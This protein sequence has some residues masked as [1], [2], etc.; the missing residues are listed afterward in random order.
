MVRS[1]ID[2]TL[3]REVDRFVRRL[4]ETGGPAIQAAALV[5][6]IEGRAVRALSGSAGRDRPGGW[7]DLTE[8]RRSPGSTL[9]PFVYALAFEDGTAAPQTLIED[10]PARFATYQPENFDRSF[11]GEVTVAQA[12][13]HSLNVPAV[14]VLDRVGAGRFASSLRFAGAD[15]EIPGRL[16]GAAGLALALGGLG[17]SASDLALLYAALG[18]GGLGRPLSLTEAEAQTS[19]S[20]P[21]ARLVSA[22]AAGEVLDILYASPSP[23]GRM[24]AGLAQGAPTVAYKTGT[25]YGF[26]DAWAAGVAGDYV[27]VVW[28]GRPDGAPRPGETGRLA[29]LPTLFDIVDAVARLDPAGVVPSNQGDSRLAP[30]PLPL[31]VFAR[32]GLP[33]DILFPPDGAELWAETAGRDFVLSGRGSGPLRWYV[34]GAPAPLNAAGAPV[35]APDGPGFYAVSL[36]D[37]EG[38]EARTRVRV[39]VA[40]AG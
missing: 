8:A 16:D 37:S 2:L 13:Q 6:Q 24:P 15:P 1:T 27:V 35:F 31:Q 38:R 18:D 29:A 39:R 30:A 7:I 36:V 25:S 17:L 23:P 28:T 12:L 19:G 40:E 11:R 10:L 3:Q 34:D 32:E 14:R 33:P 21:G 22:E 20:R 26:R 9:K 5:V 4:A